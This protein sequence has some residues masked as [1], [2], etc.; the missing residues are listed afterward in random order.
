MG[1]HTTIEWADS[2]VNAST[3]CDG[4]E[5]WKPG[6]GGP[7][8]AG[9]FH[10]QRLARS[11]P[12][13][14]S[15][16]FDEVRLAP[17][18]VAKTAAWP[19]LTGTDR[20]D[21]PWLNGMPRLIFTGD[22]SDIMSRG[23]PPE[24]IR[25][26]IVS[27]AASPK[28]SRHIYM[29]LTKQGRQLSRFAKWL[30]EEG[31]AWP[32]NLWAGVS[33]TSNKTIKRIDALKQVP[34]KFKFVSMEPIREFVDLT[35]WLFCQRCENEY[36]PCGRGAYETPL[37]NAAGGCWFRVCGCEQIDLVIV[38]GQSRQGKHQPA[39]FDLRW[40]RQYVKDCKDAGVACF[41]KQIGS[42][43]F[44]GTENNPG[45]DDHTYFKVRDSHGGDWSEWPE[46]IRVRQ[47]PRAR[48]KP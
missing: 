22:M 11:L 18:R 13:L 27:V 20:A 12:D 30:D 5:L 3:G 19:D 8:Y 34:A 36:T 16:T 47:M 14:Y 42:R 39:P 10:E 35:P 21:K 33:V 38:G 44:I 24:Y 1:Q 46:D 32:E 48:S 45:F 9:N 41:I 28:G 23:I 15:P 26:E 25:D 7:C 29:I 40:A 37:D 17:G 4:C 6:V 31:I 43:P 2:T